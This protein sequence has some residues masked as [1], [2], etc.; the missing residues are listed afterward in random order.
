[1]GQFYLGRITKKRMAELEFKEKVLDELEVVVSKELDEAD[2]VEFIK[3]KVRR[4]NG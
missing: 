2:L 1:M 4:E 3:E